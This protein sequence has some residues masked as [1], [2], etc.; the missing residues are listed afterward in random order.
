MLT[1]NRATK[2]RTK[3]NAYLT[4]QIRHILAAANFTYVLHSVNT[5]HSGLNQSFV[6]LLSGEP[7][8]TV[9]TNINDA[10]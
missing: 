9:S 7:I 2:Y 8:A 10:V 3:L 1:H 5:E 4:C 6:N